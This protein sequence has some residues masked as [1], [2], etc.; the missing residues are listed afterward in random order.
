MPS[1]RGALKFSTAIFTSVLLLIMAHYCVKD[2]PKGL[3]GHGFQTARSL[4]QHR[5]TCEYSNQVARDRPIPTTS[6]SPLPSLRLKRSKT[7]FPKR[8]P[9][10]AADQNKEVADRMGSQA[11]IP[12]S[13]TSKKIDAPQGSGDI[14]MAEPELQIPE[15]SPEPA[16]MQVDPYPPTQI[17]TSGRA[18]RL[19]RRFRDELPRRQ[20]AVVAS[21]P[22]ETPQSTIRRLTLIVRDQLQI[23]ANPFGLLRHYLH[24]PSYDPDAVVPIDELCN[25]HERFAIPVRTEGQTG[26]DA[27]SEERSP[28]WPFANMS[29]WRL[30]SWANSG[31]RT[32]S[33]SETTRLVNDVLLQEDFNSADLEG[34]DAH[35]E[36]LRLDRAQKTSSNQP[37]FQEATV[38]IEV[39]SGNKDIEPQQFSV[40]GL[41]YRSIISVIKSIFAEPLAEK[42]HFTPFKLFRTLPGTESFERLY[43]ELYNSDAFI[44]EHDRVQ[45][46]PPPPD[47]P[48]CKLE[49]VVLG[50][51]F[52]SD[53]THLASFGNASLW[54]I[55]MM[56]GNLS[57]YIRSRPNSG[58][59]QHIA[60]IPSLPPS[61]HAFASRF[62][63]KWSITKQREGLLTHCRRELMHAI[64]IFLLDDEFLHACK[65]GI[66]IR[67]HDG[68][69]RRFY[70]RIFTYSAD[71][72][73][74]VLLATIR[75]KGKCPCPRCLVEKSALDRMGL[76]QDLRIR[77]TRFRQLLTDT[78]AKARDFIYRAGFPINGTAVDAL[79]KE[80]SSIPTVNAFV[81]RLGADFSVPRMLVVDLLHE[82][83]LGVWRT[84]FTHLIRVLYAI[85]LR[86]PEVVALL[87]RRFHQVPAFGT[88]IRRFSGNASE[89]KKLAARDFEDLLQASRSFNCSCAIPVFEQ[90]LP[91]TEQN[92]Q[93][94][95]LLYRL[96][97]WHALAKLRLHSE[98]TLGWLETITKEV[99]VL[100]RAFRDKTASDFNTVDLPREQE[101]RARRQ[102]AALSGH[103]RQSSSA[104]APST[105]NRA[106]SNR[107]LNLFT[108]KFH[109]MGDY[110]PTIRLFATIDNYSTQAGELAH[111][112]VKAFYG[113]TNK[114]DAQAQIAKHYNRA[115][116]LQEAK[117]RLK[118]AKK[119]EQSN[120][121]SSMS[122]QVLERHPHHVGMESSTVEEDMK[123]PPDVHH[124]ISENTS[125]SV[126]LYAFLV[127]ENRDDPAKKDFWPKLQD[128]LLGRLLKRGFDGDSYGSFTEAER[129]SISLYKKRFYAA[130]TMRINYTTYDVRRDQDV[131]NPR[132]DHCMVMVR[133]ADYDD[134]KK[135]PF[136]YAR[137]L[138]I[139][140]ADVLRLD[141]GQVQEI[142]HMEFLWVRW[143]GAEP[144]YRWGRKVAR[145]PKIGFVA[146]SDPYAFGFL[147]PGLVIRAC[148]LIPDFVTG[149]T[150]ELLQTRQLTAARP[151]GEVDDWGSFYVN[152]FVDRD[153]FMRHAGGGVGHADSVVADTESFVGDQL[154]DEGNDRNVSMR[155]SNTGSTSEDSDDTDEDTG[156][157]AIANSDF[158]DDLGPD[159]GE[160]LYE[161]YGY[162]SP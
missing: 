8:A 92:N 91:K 101:A 111:R 3:I 147:D 96:A 54:P 146:E 112:T 55:Y 35:S 83:E 150:S 36:S 29:I 124:F 137:V 59:C 7:T 115:K 86:G 148:H 62:F 132:T 139:F 16:P 74:K 152:I 56:F 77:T 153:M 95:K 13:D 100:M 109:A 76:F 78:V 88:T 61:F 80:T 38:A 41:Q 129:N 6:T 142:E 40:P 93:L 149:R 125:H 45:R 85:P 63:T 94:S 157:D 145:L 9:Q 21:D 43:S 47:Q 118:K 105:T 99:G 33:E 11:E 50:L 73:E 107:T 82:I 75:D 23:A 116:H 162:G 72:P 119:L 155:S 17:T 15:V 4:Q 103:P 27:G 110:T 5:R 39:P 138:G 104:A 97:E 123:I 117:A 143:M 136:W 12:Q 84:L 126:S 87:D 70:P 156:D 102:A 67:C 121:A 134:P 122:A 49:K 140:H 151:V 71:Y 79:L 51:M 159:D 24:R 66:V 65:Y 1:L 46:L 69:D 144:H 18:S 37:K 28:P 130:K 34:F 81:H 161:D 127:N 30:M 89:M 20:P 53:S 26:L 98:T 114:R 141:N 60:Y 158:S 108:Y 106:T 154:D 14:Q 19:P 31:G 44:E 32:K 10:L 133:S 160:D 58:A 128:H 68:K 22:D 2:C 90:L 135:H 42:F 64:W 25:R 52:W 48:H 113:L 131:I 57:K 120:G